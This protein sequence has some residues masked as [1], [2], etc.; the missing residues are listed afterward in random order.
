MSHSNLNRGTAALT[1]CLSFLFVRPLMAADGW[2]PF[3][4][5]VEDFWVED[6]K[7]FRTSNN[8]TVPEGTSL[9]IHCAWTVRPTQFVNV[10]E[11][12][13]WN[14]N[15]VTADGHTQGLFPIEIPPDEY[16]DKQWESG[17]IIG[18]GTTSNSVHGTKKLEGNFKT[19]WNAVGAG[20]HKLSCLLDSFEYNLDLEKTRAN[21]RRE[22][23]VTVLGS[24][25][26][27]AISTMETAAV[28]SNG[29]EYVSVGDLLG[30]S[31][32]SR[33]VQED[34]LARYLDRQGST[35]DFWRSLE[36][37]DTFDPADREELRAL[38]QLGELV[39]FEPPLLQH[40]KSLRES[41]ELESLQ[42]LARFDQQR[43]RELLE[44]TAGDNGI[45][46][47][48]SIPGRTPEE[49]L[50]NYITSL[51]EPLE[52]LFPSDSLRHALMGAT[53]ADSGNTVPRVAPARTAAPGI[54]A[55]TAQQDKPQA[56]PNPCAMDV[57]YYVPK[58]PVVESSSSSLRVG[59][60]VQLQCRFEKRTRQ[61]EWQQ[62]DAAAQTANSILKSA[63]ESGSRYSGIVSINDGTVGVATSPVDGSSFEN[64]KL[65]KFDEPGSQRISCQVDNP[66]RF[67]AEGE[68]TYLSATIS[69]DVIA[70]SDG[71]TFS[72]FERGTARR[73]ATVERTSQT[74]PV[75][76]AGR[77]RLL[78]RSE[79]SRESSDQALVQPQLP[80]A[81]QPGGNDVINPSLNPQ[82]EVPSL[83][84]D[85]TAISVKPESKPLP[86][87]AVPKPIG[88]NT[89]HR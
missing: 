60:Q 86:E 81:R 33:E 21:N 78:E 31:L 46:L 73:V 11:K 32:V 87:L 80:V 84:R 53:D 62:C 35:Q 85:H 7:G 14:G 30:L 27:E 20:N 3:D 82:P 52:A 16:G 44:K 4:M 41:G 89:G 40:I 76:A 47:P 70:R 68:P 66:F 43:W 64:T 57:T 36:D 74:A 9:T 13:W 28:R 49:R 17:G 69:V 50:D 51:R 10:K 83:K 77:F 88:N 45:A 2:F 54:R 38:L 22:I 12:L 61:L 6:E 59:D 25:S 42:D 79:I 65:W 19:G 26:V 18:I 29:A 5:S 75:A 24:P 55:I 63:Q 67:A 37:D 1:V 72:G 39:Q 71:R 8:V 34:F 23:T 15:L 48:E 58:Q 56:P